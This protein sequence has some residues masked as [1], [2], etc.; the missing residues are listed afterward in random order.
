MSKTGN[1]LLAAAALLGAAPFLLT[2]PLCGLYLDDYSFLRLLEGAAPSELWTAFLRYVPGRNLHIP[3]FYALLELTGRSVFAMH[4]VGVAF[5]ALNAALLFLL[6]RRLTGLGSIALAAAAAF[7]A[8]PNHGETHFWIN[9]IPQCQIPTALVLTAFLLAARGG[10]LAASAVYAVALF[11]YDQV[12]FLWPLLLAVAWRRDRAPRPALYGAA[13]AGLLALNA[14]HIA[15]RYLSPHA[16][17]GRPLI[18]AA[19]FLDRCRDALAATGKGLLPWPTSS[20]AHWAW[21]LPVVVLALAAAVWLLRAVRAQAREENAALA[22]WTGGSGWLAAAAGGAAWTVLAYFPNLFWYLSPR[23]NL[24]PS[25]GWSLAVVSLGA[26][27]LSRSRRAAA[28][29]PPLACLF[30]AAATVSNV[31]EGTQWIDARRLHDGFAAAVRRL[32]APVDS[33]FVVGAPRSLRRAPAFNLPQDVVLAAGRALRRPSLDAGDY[34]LSPTR[35]GVVYRNDL[36]IGPAETFRWLPAGEANVLV[37]DAPKRTFRCAAALAVASPDGSSHRLALR[38]NE[39]CAFVLP[40]SADA[41][42]AASTPGRASRPAETGPRAGGLT[43]LSAAAFVQAETTR[44][45]LEWRVETP[46]RRTLAFIPRLKDASG[47]LLLDSVFPSR[48]G[49]RPYPTIWPLVDDLAPGLRLKPG[50]AL[51]QVFLLAR[52]PKPAA[53]ATFLELDAFELTDAGD[54]APLGTA[55]APIAVRR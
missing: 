27:T 28:V 21:S 38:P 39:D 35:R 8:A 29:L 33:V 24:L 49:K 55:A 5:D 51:R 22:S 34:Q 25:I 26:W 37:F 17:G 54:A 10:L 48:G 9:N 52:A 20:H 1:R 47:R 23:H 14:A 11:T 45:E 6:V 30:F 40:A 50:Q 43:L 13:A 31:H 41:F 7:A 2:A 19:D 4:L 42:L 46:P 32:S 15:L 44:L 36:T 3:F 16:Q 53:S 12:F 18:R